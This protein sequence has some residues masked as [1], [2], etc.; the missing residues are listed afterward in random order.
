M[1]EGAEN[2]PEVYQNQAVKLG[3]ALAAAV[4][5]TFADS[6]GDAVHRRVQQMAFYQDHTPDKW[7]KQQ[8]AL[9]EQLVKM[10][11]RNVAV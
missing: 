6:A 10:A 1:K 4:E 2:H 7:G 9:W 5:E 11:P 8:G 3:A